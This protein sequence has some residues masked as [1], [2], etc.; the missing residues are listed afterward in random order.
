MS[1]SHY[2]VF[3][4]DKYYPKGG[5]DDFKAACLTIEEA[6][7]IAANT[8]GDWWQVVKVTMQDKMP[9]YIIVKDGM[10]GYD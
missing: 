6:L 8:T 5:L 7:V 4:G 2:L 3:S 9:Q 10:R 1:D